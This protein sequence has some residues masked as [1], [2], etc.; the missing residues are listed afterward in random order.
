M[1]QP[2]PG[3]GAAAGLKPIRRRNRMINSCLEC[4]KRK[5]KCSK[6]SPSCVNCLKAARDCLYIG[7]RLDEAS[8]LRLAEI[9]EKQGSLERQLERDVAK[10]TTIKGSMQQRILADEVE[11]DEDDE[12]D[13]ETTPLVALDLTYEDDAD[14]ADEMIDLGIQIG[15]MRITE[16]IGGLSRPRISEELSA[17][18]SGPGRPP[19][20]AN[21]G[22]GGPPPRGPSP[23]MGLPPGLD[24]M[25]DGG[26]SDMSI[27]DFLKP[28]V[29]YI[30]PT[31]GFFFGQVVDQPSILG[32]LPHRAAA[33]RFMRQYFVS[34]HP[35]APCT[36]RSSLESTYASF[37]ED[38]NANYEPRPSSQAIIFAAMFS[39]ALAMDDGDIFRETGGYA[40]ANW[41]ACLKLGTETALGKANFL[42]TTK[43]ET[44]QA[45]I[46]Y[47]LPLCRAEV[48]RAHSVLVGAAVRMAE[49]MGLHRDGEAYGLTPL[50]THVRRL[51]WHQL[52]FL[53][54]RTCEAQGPKPVIRRDDYDTKLPLNCNEEDL[55]H[56]IVPPEAAEYWTTSTLPLIRFEINEMMRT[57]WLDR[58]RLESHKTSLTAVLT[59][60]EHFRR[61]MSEKYD[62]LLDVSQPLQRYAKCVMY[63]L[64][65][66]LHVMVLHPY[67]SNAATPMPPRLSSLLIT[68]G[69][70]IVELAIQLETNPVFQNW[71]WYLGAYFQYQI[72]LLLATEVY[73]RPQSRDADRIWACL[74]YVFGLD[75]RLP[76]EAKAM[77]LLSEIQGKTAVYMRMRK[78]RG[79]T[80][81]SRAQPAQNAVAGTGGGSS[82]R[83]A[84]QPPHPP[85]PP[86]PGGMHAANEHTSPVQPGIPVI[87][88]PAMVFA[89][90]S[91]GQA[92]WSFPPNQHESPGSSDTSSI[93]HSQSLTG[94]TM[95]G[96]MAAQ[97]GNIMDTIDWDTINA[98]FPNDPQTGGLSI[99]GYHDPTNFGVLDWGA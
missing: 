17:G 54:I 38:I 72:A 56:A 96:A 31:S 76:P 99:Q 18:L 93:E 27:P 30:A 82:S 55:T 34:V 36:H 94:G 15:K 78:M 16:R 70:M 65:Y 92:L 8:Q 91:D 98:L 74:D 26:A 20:P 28:S 68:S 62:H 69:I 44:M 22:Y 25:S 14:G 43:V 64:T 73:F 37:W 49:C 41:L 52:C 51:I 67:H 77:H 10:S 95:G 9:K 85:L 19:G 50:E 46:M 83:G 66:R 86:P 89:G 48:S 7:P 84:S 42:R 2:D 11:Y 80:N 59:K 4:R 63:L 33:D 60:I 39:G 3:A 75:R 87:P 5:L 57:I 45:F 88:P 6:T 47:M 58:R 13:L 40:K 1:S 81:I 35:I 23:G 79:P 24:N 12:R 53:D 29:Q 61:R 97:V 90:V 21:P 71:A 32:F